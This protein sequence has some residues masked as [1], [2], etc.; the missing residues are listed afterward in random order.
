MIDSGE[1]RFNASEQAV[2]DDI[3]DRLRAQGWAKHV[4]I[5]SLLADWRAFSV[6]VTHDA[7]TVED[8][9]N[10]LIVRDGLEIVL[11]ECPET[12]RLKVEHALRKADTEFLALTQEDLGRTLERYSRVD[13]SAGWW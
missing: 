7:M 2:L 3:S 1:P 6:S 10:E 9:T 5:E 12:L 11:A 8:Y 4:S 13:P